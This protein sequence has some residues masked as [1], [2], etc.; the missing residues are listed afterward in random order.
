MVASL[1]QVLPDLDLLPPAFGYL[2]AGLFGAVV[3]SF[4]NVVIH[5]VPIRK[6]VVFPHSRCPVCGH[7]IAFYD[8]IPILSYI[9]L[10][11]K[12]R[13]CKTHIS[14]RYPAVE[15]LTA[16]LFVTVAWRDGAIVQAPFDMI[17]VA[18][19]LSLIFINAEYMILPNS[20]TFPGLLFAL[21]VKLVIPLLG[22]TY[23]FDN[24][25]AGTSASLPL[26][27]GLLMGGAIGAI[28]GGGLIWL[29]G[30]I[31]EKLRGVAVVGM[32]N[33]KMQFMVG[34]YL[35]WRLTLL[36]LAI[37]ILVGLISLPLVT[38]RSNKLALP[39]GVFLGV[40]TIAALLMGNNFLIWL[41]VA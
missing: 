15:L 5:R 25:F 31:W 12:C 28:V 35:G 7:L 27:L 24:P 3:G 19:I 21:V 17:F 18:A 23:Y 29:F 11:G 37:A 8:N 2:V 20:I 1:I 36:S 22:H 13:G 38:N 6:S 9:I 16:I 40:G 30:F 10:G 41:G 33:V 39:S 32:G 4:L 14:A 34:A 26:S